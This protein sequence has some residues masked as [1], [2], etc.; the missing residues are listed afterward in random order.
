MQRNVIKVKFSKNNSRCIIHG[1]RDGP[2]AIVNSRGRSAYASRGDFNV[3]VV[4]WSKGA[5]TIN[6]MLAKS[7]IYEIGPIVAQF[8]E[9]V[10]KT[11]PDKVLLS[12]V[13]LIGHSLGAHLAGVVGKSMKVGKIPVI[14]GLD[15]AGPL[16]SIKDPEKRLDVGDAE[17]VEVIHTDRGLQGLGEPMGTADFYPNFGLKQPGCGSDLDG[18]CSHQRSAMYWAESITSNKGFWSVPCLGYEDIKNKTCTISTNP[19]ITMGGEP[20]NKGKAS[21]VYYLETASQSPFALGPL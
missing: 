3:I 4:D 13:Y 16:F 20:P 19:K 21:G 2:D 15:P 18:A 7:R 11:Y 9:F 12:D 8:I 6:Y 5:D 1:F 17:Y 14:F 10:L